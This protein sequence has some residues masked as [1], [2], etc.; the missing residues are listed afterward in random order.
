MGTPK[1]K[2]SLSRLRS[3]RA[4]KRWKA[5]QLAFDKESG[6]SFIPHR[7]NPATGLYKGRQVITV[8]AAK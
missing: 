2:T 7:I 4:A 5:G 3:R 8:E 6:T 1:R